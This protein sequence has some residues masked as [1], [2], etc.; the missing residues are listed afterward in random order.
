MTNRNGVLVRSNILRRNGTV[1]PI[2][3]TNRNAVPVRSGPFRAL[4]PCKFLL[5]RLLLFLFC[6]FLI[7]L[8]NCHL[9]CH[10]LVYKRALVY[11]DSDFASSCEIFKSFD[12]NVI[13]KQCP[14]SFC[15]P[16]F[17]LR[18]FCIFSM[19]GSVEA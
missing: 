14:P 16:V 1:T 12:S 15:W 2:H 18:F 3:F 13:I 17:L 10:P 6:H 5:L 9:S 4:Q 8:S 19:P 7:F 11:I